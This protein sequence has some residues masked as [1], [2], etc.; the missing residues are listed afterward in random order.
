ME[1]FAKIKVRTPE[2]GTVTLI[3]MGAGGF[4]EANATINL[5]NRISKRK[6]ITQFEILEFR[7]QPIILSRYVS[8]VDVQ[9]KGKNRKQIILNVTAEN[10]NEAKELF[11]ETMYCRE[12]IESFEIVH[13]A[14]AFNS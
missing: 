13:T 14:I 6:W 12:N 4:N 11:S 3:A 7:D 2:K 10:L 9:F 1:Y 5:I 8:F